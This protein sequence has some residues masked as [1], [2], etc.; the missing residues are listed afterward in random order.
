M[1][2][3][4]VYHNPDFLTFYQEPDPQAIDLGR[5]YLA[6]IV[7]TD[8]PETAYRLTQHVQ[9]WYENPGVTAVVRSRSTSVGDVLALADGRLLVVASFGFEPLADAVLPADGS[10]LMQQLEAAIA[11]LAGGDSRE[12]AAALE[13]SASE[14]GVL[15]TALLFALPLLAS[16][17]GGEK[18][19]PY[20]ALLARFAAEQARWAL[21]QAD[22]EG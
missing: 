3:I 8:D 2:P 21:A 14:V 13:A 15:Y 22:G 12:A 17:A 5:L 6:A 20:Q 1:M 9:T 7:A 10:V 4:R 11:A 18:V 19:K 16:V